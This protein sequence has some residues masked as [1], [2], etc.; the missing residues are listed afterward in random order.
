MV[1]TENMHQL[2]IGRQ[3]SFVRKMKLLK[4]NLFKLKVSKYIALVCMLLMLGN[5]C[6]FNSS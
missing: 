3:K 1:E 4:K 6:S 5:F 2:E